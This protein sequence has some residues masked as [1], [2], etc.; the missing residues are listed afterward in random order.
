MNRA[1]QIIV[2]CAI[3]FA[4][5]SIE[6]FTVADANAQSKIITT[7]DGDAELDEAE[8]IARSYINQ[9]IAEL[10]ANGGDDPRYSLKI[11]F[12]IVKNGKPSTE[13]IW[14]DNLRSLG[15][16]RF[17]GKLANEPFW[18]EGFELQD[19]VEFTENMIYD[20][21]IE[22]D[23][24]LYGHFSTRVLLLRLPIEQQQSRIERL[25]ANPI[26]PSFAP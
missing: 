6:I 16:G 15:K 5:T 1:T 14:V 4:Y 18:M 12:D 7:Q 23:G 8:R 13:V 11:G 2:F 20:W 17:T 3:I 24:Q 26:P 25:K 10:N 22:H 9:F 19:D 21:G